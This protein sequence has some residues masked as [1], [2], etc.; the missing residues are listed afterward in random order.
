M[1]ILHVI[2]TLSAK[3]GGPP[4]A[5]LAMARAVAA[6]GH[7]V[8]IHAT[9]HG[10][11][12][13]DIAA[14]VAAAGP[15]VRI[16]L[17][18][19]VGPA[20]L[21]RHSSISLWKSLVEEI[22]RCDLV[23][24]HSLYMFHDWAVW[25]ICKAADVPYILRP[26]GTLDPYLLAHHRWRKALANVAFQNRV[27]RDATLVNFTSERERDQS[28]PLIFDRP[29]VIVPTR[30]D[31]DPFKTMRDGG[32][33]RQRYPEIGSRRIVLFLGRLNFKKG[34][35]IL[36]PAFA[37]ALA[38]FSDI[39]LVFV[40]PDDGFGEAARAIVAEHRIVEHTTFT[41]GLDRSGVVDAFSAAFMFVLP[42]QGENFA[43]AAA[44]AMSAGLPTLVSDQ[45][46]IAGDAANHNACCVL[47]LEV[48][49]WTAA[50]CHFLDEPSKARALGERARAYALA[51]F[52][53]ADIGRK[54]LAMYEQAVSLHRIHQRRVNTPRSIIRPKRSLPTAADRKL[55]I[56]H[57]ISTLSQAAG[58]PPVVAKE[59]ACAVT[60]LGHDVS[61]HAT[62]HGMSR[63]DIAELKAS[64][65]H[66]V[67]ISVH[68]H[69]PPGSVTRHS[70]LGL[71]R[72]LAAEIPRCDV[73]HVHS[74]YMFHDWAVWH[75]CRKANVPYILQ[76]HGTLDP[77]LY[78]HHRW[79]KT[80]AEIAFQNRVTRDAALI[81]YTTEA[82]RDLAQPFAFGRPSVVIPLGVDLGRFETLPPP[83]RF[84]AK[85]PEIGH[86]R[87]V[88]FLSRLNFKKGLEILIP[89]FAAVAA[90]RDDI[91]LVLAGSDG[92]ME[93]TARAMILEHR[94]NGRTTFTG[95]LG[96]A[97]V[98]E[99]FAAASIFVL[100]SYTENFGLA[101]AEALAAGVPSI[102]SPDVQIAPPAARAGACLI[103]ERS[104]SAWADA[105]RDLLGDTQRT[106]TMAQV[107][108][109][110]AK[111]HFSW[112]RIG[113]ELVA[114]YNLAIARAPAEPL[115]AVLPETLDSIG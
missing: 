39:H 32:T 98:A 111:E 57:V 37:G 35:D 106:E 63:A 83:E 69:L 48:D 62:D 81:S 85:H 31:T 16:S 108:R 23:H 56:V 64:D 66:G 17:H 24:L 44:E 26:H 3:A 84:R 94:L 60:D 109:S 112:S 102:L 28:Q 71:W 67:H 41:G 68:R 52:D 73:V 80:G 36:I 9:D 103:V 4:V 91:H 54:V 74:L 18:R 47:P 49:A 20:S 75:L 93:T 25:K 51:T 6:L 2:S 89:A 100:P 114:T 53:L 65:W 5:V 79:R 95:H 21:T 34:I 76:P 59:M 50:L 104:P 115:S 88:L 86:R 45:V 99:A 12:R 40:G 27:T 87:I 29:N 72:A 11:T 7:D 96:A 61:I 92:G 101:A 55:R 90:E 70:S 30:I 105:L 77:F 82:E 10:M 22:P 15:T 43:I 110:Y 1:R 46:A 33:F 78:G 38:R 42:S 13:D 19:Y 8:S 113:A 14:A 58:G 97:Q 107:A